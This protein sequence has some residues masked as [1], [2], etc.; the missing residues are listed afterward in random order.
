MMD[1]LIPMLVICIIVGLLS[2]GLIKFI[3]WLAE[4]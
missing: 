1:A 3:D 2:W 4:K